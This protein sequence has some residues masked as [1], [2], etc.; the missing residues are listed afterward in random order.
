MDIRLKRPPDLP[1]ADI[2]THDSAKVATAAF[3]ELIAGNS[4]QKLVLIQAE[5]L[6]KDGHSVWMEV[7]GSLSLDEQN[8]PV[9]IAGISRDITERREKEKLRSRL[10]E[11]QKMEALARLADGVAYDFSGL[12]GAIDERLQRLLLERPNDPELK[13]SVQGILDLTQRGGDLTHRL[14]TISRKQRIEMQPVSVNSLMDDLTG[15]V[16]QVLGEKIQ[17]QQTLAEDLATISA[18]PAQLEQ[19]ILTLALRARADM[20]EGGRFF[21]QTAQV[22]PGGKC[23]LG[24]SGH[25]IGRIRYDRTFRY[26]TRLG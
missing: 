3:N 24:K 10:R 20:E 5:H 21:I 14:L 2:L 1:L 8:Q 9:A 13:Q 17:L 25:E 12:L 19:V 16:C 6:H 18:D 4:S 26:R 22:F 15:V 23:Q 11:T 7:S